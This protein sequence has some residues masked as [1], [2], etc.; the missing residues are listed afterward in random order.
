VGDLYGLVVT[1]RFAA[2][3]AGDNTV[4]GGLVVDSCGLVVID[5]ITL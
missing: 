2:A 3:A 5:T 1:D 4:A